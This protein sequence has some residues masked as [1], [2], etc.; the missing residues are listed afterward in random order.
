MYWPLRRDTWPTG[1]P[2][3][4]RESSCATNWLTR[5][6]LPF[7]L[8]RLVSS[9]KLQKYGQAS[10]G[11][12]T[13]E[14]EWKGGIRLLWPGLWWSLL[15]VFNASSEL[16]CKTAHSIEAH[17]LTNSRLAT[18]VGQKT[19]STYAVVIWSVKNRWRSRRDTMRKIWKERKNLP[20][21]TRMALHLQGRL[22]VWRRKQ[23]QG[24]YEQE[25]MREAST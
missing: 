10:L 22:P 25:L 6:Q 4:E 16:P 7:L 20:R 1:N 9:K 15:A 23:P 17:V 14:R 24:N 3:E 21:S 12:E 13:D 18:G 19:L 8:Q 2:C 5:Y 11:D